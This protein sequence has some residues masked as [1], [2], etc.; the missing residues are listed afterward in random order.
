MVRVLQA[1]M[2]GNYELYDL[3][4]SKAGPAICKDCWEKASKR[5]TDP[6]DT[7]WVSTKG[8][9][10]IWWLCQDHAEKLKAKKSGNVQFVRL[11]KGVAPHPEAC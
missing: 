9:S 3:S 10:M 5:T 6:L 2:P 1:H 4:S 8:G 7:V 11:V